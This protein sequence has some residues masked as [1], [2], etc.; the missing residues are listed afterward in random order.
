MIYIITGPSGVGKNTIINELSNHINIHFSVS[1]TTREKRQGE[2]DG[3]D[4]F[5][6]SE[7]E[8]KNLIDKNFFIEFEQYGD[9]FYGTGKDQIKNKKEVILLDLEVN[10]ATKLLK[11]YPHFIGIFIDIDND[12][13]KERLKIRGHD[14]SF[15]QER[16]KLANLQREKKHL[17]NFNIKNVDLNTSVKEIID[18]IY[19]LEER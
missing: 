19:D 2:V 3:K 15:I 13:L 17:Y 9:A 12:S 4:Y 16:M 8:F 10:G 6:V 7:E 11:Q 1:H 18:I 14:N 5:F